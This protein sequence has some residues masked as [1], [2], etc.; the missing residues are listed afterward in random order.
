MK[1]EDAKKITQTL[2]KELSR[3]NV[4]NIRQVKA[5]NLLQQVVQSPIIKHYRNKCE[6]SCGLT[7]D[8]E[9]CVGF[10]GGRMAKRFCPIV[11]A[12]D[13]VLI[14]ENMR[15][16]CEVFTEE[17]VKK[18]DLDVFDEFQRTGFWKRLT[19]RDFSGD[20]MI[21]I[22]VHPFADEEKIKECKQK[23]LD[24][25]L[26][27]GNLTDQFDFSVRS[28]YWGV[29]ENVSD[30]I[31]YE[32]IGGAPFVYESILNV[33][34]R[35]SPH[36]FFQSNSRGAAQLYTI[37]GDFLGLPNVD[38]ST[39]LQNDEQENN[40]QISNLSKS[41]YL[42]DICCGAGTI[43]QCL[44]RR[45]EY[46]MQAGKFNGSYACIGVEIVDQAVQDAKRNAEENGFNKQK[47]RYVS[48]DAE[49]VFR[50]LNNYFN[51]D[52][53]DENLSY[54][55]VLDPPRAG[56]STKVILSCRKLEKMRKLVYVSC[57]PKL[58][59]NNLV[60][61][62]RPESKKYEGT[63]FTIE[64]ICPVDMFPQTRHCEWVVLLT[65]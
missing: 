36:T 1:Y 28:V 65:R 34:F 22:T 51:I 60:S 38:R 40:G 3:A 64:K 11:P 20:C 62:C 16:I 8:S 29:N 33:R 9:I 2:L 13:S 35:V 32:H 12:N 4:P 31:V 39:N 47:C 61:L 63:P 41:I 54:L 50:Q 48:G 55:G 30:P 25:F 42:L 27:F 26:K 17:I 43:G 58:A 53:N 14:T 49:S 56:L 37:I 24:T 6:F 57:D 21:I 15:K 23:I 5:G 7:V 45:I 18:S 52:P 19:V 59:L 46:A 10:V 44:S